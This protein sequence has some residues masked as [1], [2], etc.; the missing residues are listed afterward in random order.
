VWWW[1]YNE[2]LNSP[3]FQNKEQK[4]IK[5]FSSK[6]IE[7]SGKQVRPGLESATAKK[8]KINKHTQKMINC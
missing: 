1:E 5:T 2:P 6:F 4:R 3:N 8:I 7:A